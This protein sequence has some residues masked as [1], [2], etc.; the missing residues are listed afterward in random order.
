MKSSFTVTAILTNPFRKV[1]TFENILGGGEDPAH[2][3]IMRAKSKCHNIKLVAEA[4]W[5]AHPTSDEDPVE[6]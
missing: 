6:M 1:V 2:D 5:S 3:A 4:Q